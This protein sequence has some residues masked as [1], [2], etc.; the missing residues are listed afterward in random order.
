[1]PYHRSDDLWA[2]LA[3]LSLG[4]ILPGLLWAVYHEFIGL[5]LSAIELT[6]IS[7]VGYGLLSWYLI[8]RGTVDR[9]SYLLVSLIWPWPLLFG[10]LFLLLLLNRG[11]QIPRGPLASTFR[12]VTTG[13]PGSIFGYGA[14]FS[15]TGIA[16]AVISRRYDERFLPAA[17]FPSPSRLIPA[18][19]GAV[20]VIAVVTAGANAITSQTASI[21]DVSPGTMDYHDPTLNVTV[22]GPVDELR[23]TVI[24][25][26]GSA[27]TKRLPRARMRGGSGTV[28]FELDYDDSYTPAEVPVSDGTYHV[29]L[30]SLAGLVVDTAS[31]DAGASAGGSLSVVPL[32]DETGPWADEPFV[33]T[34]RNASERTVALTVTNDGA[35]HARM[36]LVIRVPDDPVVF[37]GVPMPPGERQRVV[38]KLAPQTVGTIREKTGGTVTIELYNSVHQDEPLA[39]ARA[40]I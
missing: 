22:V 35:F 29:R 20:V 5:Y 16:V 25:P 4:L 24:A 31:F 12:T 11:E 6:L 32:T 21:R 13:W 40:T 38:F 8:D 33:Y 19:V 3:L 15:A 18:I 2:P 1:M 14:V 39:T 37:D 30:A 26:D 28:P 10:V 7:T 9:L 34:E 27:V 23:V 17:R 36:T